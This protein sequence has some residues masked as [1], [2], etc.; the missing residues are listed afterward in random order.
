[1]TISHCPQPSQDGLSP[2][3]GAQAPPPAGRQLRRRALLAA[4]ALLA[5]L[6]GT[7]VSPAATAQ[8]I[9]TEARIVAR[10]LTDGRIEF[11]LQQRR[12]DT[13]GQRQL[14]RSRYFPTTAAVGRWLAS[15]PISIGGSRS[16]PAASSL[17]HLTIA[18]LNDDSACALRNDGTIACWGANDHG[19]TDAPGG[20]YTAIAAILDHT[21][22]IATD[23]TMDCWGQM[24]GAVTGDNPVTAPEGRFT[25]FAGEHGTTC[26]VRTDGSLG[27]PDFWVA[28]DG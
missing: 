22:A 3:L 20:A 19:Q 5:V 6:A 15:T 17:Q 1:M 2:R 18:T 4:G 23:G 28:G 9:D 24:S 10:K 8:Q 21:C 7:L 12:D 26:G 16:S 11:G 25:A 27:C 13:W 14:P